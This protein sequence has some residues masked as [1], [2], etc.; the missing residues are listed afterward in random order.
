[1]DLTVAQ[2]QAADDQPCSEFSW[3]SFSEKS[4]IGKGSFGTIYKAKYKE[5]WYVIKVIDLGSLSDEKSMQAIEEVNIHSKCKSQYIVDYYDSFLDEVDKGERLNIVLEYCENGDLHSLLAKR[6]Q[7]LPEQEIWSFF[8]QITLGVHHLHSQD[9]IHRDMKSLNI[10]L[11]EGNKVKIGDLGSASDNSQD[12]GKDQVST[13]YYFS[14]ELCRGEKYTDKCDI[15]ALGCILYEMCYLKRPFEGNEF[16]ELKDRILHEQFE[17]IPDFYSKELRTLSAQLLNKNATKRPSAEDLIIMDNFI[18]NSKKLGIVIP[19]KIKFL[20]INSTKESFQSDVSYSLAKSCEKLSSK[21]PDLQNPKNVESFAPYTDCNRMSVEPRERSGNKRMMTQL[22]TALRNTNRNFFAI[23]KKK[24]KNSTKKRMEYDKLVR[25]RN[26]Q[27]MSKSKK[28]ISRDFNNIDPIKHI[29]HACKEENR[30]SSSSDKY[31]SISGIRNSTNISGF[32][33]YSKI[34]NSKILHQKDSNTVYSTLSSRLIEERKSAKKTQKIAKKNEEIL[35]N[36][37]CTMKPKKIVVCDLASQQNSEVDRSMKISVKR[38]RLKKEASN[39]SKLEQIRKSCEVVGSSE[40]ERCLQK[41]ME[42]RI[43]QKKNQESRIPSIREKVNMSPDEI[44]E[45]I[46]SLTKSRLKKFNCMKRK[47][48]ASEVKGRNYFQIHKTASSKHFKEKTNSNRFSNPKKKMKAKRLVKERSTNDNSSAVKYLS[49]QFSPE[50]LFS[51]NIQDATEEGFLLDPDAKSGQPL[52]NESISISGSE[53]IDEI[54]KDEINLVPDALEI[55]QNPFELSHVSDENY[56]DTFSEPQ[57]VKSV[58]KEFSAD[59]NLEQNLGIID[60]TRNSGRLTARNHTSKKNRK[61]YLEVLESPNPVPPSFV[62]S[63]E[64]DL[65][66]NTEGRFSKSQYEMVKN[67]HSPRNEGNPESSPSKEAEDSTEK[68]CLSM[69]NGDEQLLQK[70]DKEV[71]KI[72]QIGYNLQKK[73]REEVS[74][75][76]PEGANVDAL[77]QLLYSK[78]LQSPT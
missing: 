4:I 71:I 27:S 66:Q 16:D 53:L 14:P 55:P 49:N 67:V 23:R 60:L 62:P 77:I 10:F 61:H 1:M 58:R 34:S 63:T 56:K 42:K 68:K 7:Y 75:S 29:Y 2:H 48:Q 44:K 15:W 72:L 24:A 32:S 51:L 38:C 19:T 50:D 17:P 21:I 36:I 39:T 54:K 74:S 6:T 20:T 76:I 31:L 70:F 25:R 8:I 52:E 45:R 26:K 35:T 37:P 46:S 47:N 64:I 13:P 9:I 5:K 11:S 30:P 65:P 78:N 33:Y 43:L 59:A 41:W 69:C 12:N 22:K 18:A 40:T 73:L 57:T 3:K 28:K